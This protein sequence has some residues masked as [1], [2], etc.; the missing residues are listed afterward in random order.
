MDSDTAKQ[1]R[2]LTRR[3]TNLE[4]KP[5]PLYVTG[6]FIPTLVGSTIAGSFTY[7]AGV[8]VVEWTLNGDRLSFQGRIRISAISVAP[9]GGLTV[10]GW[11]YA[12]MS[13]ATMAVAGGGNVLFWHGFTFAAAYTQVG[14]Q[15]NNGLSNGILVKSGSGLTALQIPGNEMGL[16]GGVFDIRFEG[17]YR[18]VI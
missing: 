4:T 18:V 17:Q 9:T 12:G 7:V 10:N 2:A 1:L 11:P 6:S 15:F 16:I 5:G 13:D 3:V 14:M 8:S